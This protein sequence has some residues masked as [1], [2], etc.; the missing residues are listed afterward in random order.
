MSTGLFSENE[1]RVA[2]ELVEAF[3]EKGR[4]S[5]YHFIFY[6]IE[7]KLAGY[8]CWGPIPATQS[9]FDL[10]WLV[11]DRGLQRQRIGSLLLAEVERRAQAAGGTRLYIDTSWTKAYHP[12]QLFYESRGY[13][14]KALL[15]DFYGPSDDKITYV[16]LL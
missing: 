15:E 6:D 10:Y 11:V 5:G 13:V 1:S 16:K 2:V 12:T 9:S 7:E 8:A 3:E 14:R 4:Q